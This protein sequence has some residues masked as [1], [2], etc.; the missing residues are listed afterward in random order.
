MTFKLRLKEGEGIHC[1]RLW[2]QGAPG[3]GN[4]ACKDPGIGSNLGFQEVTRLQSVWPGERSEVHGGRGGAR[5]VGRGLPETLG[6]QEVGSGRSMLN[7]PHDIIFH[8]VCLS[9]ALSCL[10]PENRPYKRTGLPLK[11]AHST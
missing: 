11:R 4:S 8:G 3:R 5:E 6:N 9:G 7:W 2:G 1:V 10:V